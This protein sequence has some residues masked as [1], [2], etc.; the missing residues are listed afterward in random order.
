[1]ILHIN[2][3]RIHLKN[4][5]EVEIEK[6]TKT[7]CWSWILGSEFFYMKYTYYKWMLK[8]RLYLKEANFQYFM[9]LTVIGLG[10]NQANKWFGSI[11]SQAII[12]YQG[13]DLND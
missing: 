12:R 5:E 10:M 9:L 8:R 2:C 1:M 3:L 4:D 11:E 7:C 6:I 13:F